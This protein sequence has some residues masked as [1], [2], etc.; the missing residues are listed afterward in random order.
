MSNSNIDDLM[1]KFAMSRLKRA[2]M[3][4]MVTPET[5]A[6]REA[7]KRTPAI[8]SNDQAADGFSAANAYNSDFPVGVTPEGWLSTQY[9]SS[10]PD[11]AYNPFQ[12][13]LSSVMDMPGFGLRGTGVGGDLLAGALAGGLSTVAARA[14][15]NRDLWQH[16]NQDLSKTPKSVQQRIMETSIQPNGNPATMSRVGNTGRSGT[17]TAPEGSPLVQ[18][19][20]LKTVPPR[21]KSQS[22]P[23]EIQVSQQVP[24]PKPLPGRL[25]GM[26]KPGEPVVQS[27]SVPQINT[28]NLV[29][30]AI[31]GAGGVQPNPRSTNPLIRNSGKLGLGVGAL[32]ALL[33]RY[34]VGQSVESPQP[35]QSYFS[36]M[37]SAPIAPVQ[38]STVPISR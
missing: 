38:E 18:A 16:I 6:Y 31:P 1:L 8:I 7:A 30:G 21:L 13:G 29:R 26:G 22:G 28:V 24:G 3:V 4:T 5:A 27:R 33:S 14:A 25:L 17:A 15:G 11:S 20:A 9:L 2:G 37:T 19:Q 32:T 35:D 34:G 12:G 36:R 23:S 10:G